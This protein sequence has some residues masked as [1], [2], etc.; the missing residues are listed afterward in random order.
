MI[1][2]HPVMRVLLCILSCFSHVQ[3]FETLWSGPPGSSVHGIL[4]AR[5][6]EWFAMPS[7][8]GSSQTRDQT[9]VSCTS[10]R[11]IFY[12]LSHLGSLR[13]LYA[14]TISTLL[15]CH[16]FSSD[17]K[18]FPDILSKSVLHISQWLSKISIV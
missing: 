10:C 5:I 17:G 12:R 9:H 18:H 16:L 3:F 15:S 14:F 4:R 1:L 2:V 13:S 11:W 6:L 8:R 7:S